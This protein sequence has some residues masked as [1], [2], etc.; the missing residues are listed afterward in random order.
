MDAQGPARRDVNLLT[1]SRRS[2]SWGTPGVGFSPTWKED[3]RELKDEDLPTGP[4]AIC[5]SPPEYTLPTRPKDPPSASSPYNDQFP[6]LPASDHSRPE[7]PSTT[8]SFESRDNP[9]SGTQVVIEPA[10]LRSQGPPESPSRKELKQDSSYG[11]SESEVNVDLQASNI[12]ARHR[13]EILRGNVNQTRLALPDERMKLQQLRQNLA[14]AS[15]DFTNAAEAL[16]SSAHPAEPDNLRLYHEALRV[17]HDDLATAE[18]NMGELEMKLFYE[19]HSLEQEEMKF[20]TRNNISLAQPPDAIS[21]QPLS[22]HDSDCTPSVASDLSDGSTLQPEPVQQYLSKLGRANYLKDKLEFL[23]DREENVLTE[24]RF[25]QRYGLHLTEMDSAWLANLPE[26]RQRTLQKLHRVEIELYD[27]Q[28]QCVDQGLFREDEYRYEPRGALFYELMDVINE[29]L[30]YK[31]VYTAVQHSPAMKTHEADL[32]NI[33]DCVNTWLLEIV[34]ESTIENWRLRSEIE[35]WY[36]DVSVLKG[37]DWADLAVSYWDHDGAGKDANTLYTLIT[38][39]PQEL[40]TTGRSM[41]I[42]VGDEMGETFGPYDKEVYVDSW[43]GTE[44][45]EGATGF[46]EIVSSKASS[47]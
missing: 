5:G 15:F 24:L 40:Q 41:L 2:G 45:T 8:V 27:L 25:R 35:S 43:S 17:A 30:E 16:M 29:V 38:K 19:E 10:S 23:D 11:A 13:V 44:V 14:N 46:D 4:V 47:I 33:Q 36:P 28:D 21:Y 42:H 3:G 22:P 12:K 37:D 18:N 34:E 7:S 39:E 32:G 31:P 1:P 20:Y 6:E 9:R 26:K